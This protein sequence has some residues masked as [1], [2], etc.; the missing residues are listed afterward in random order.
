MNEA[1]LVSEF[2]ERYLI[3]I[4]GYVGY[5]LVGRAVNKVP[6]EYFPGKS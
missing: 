2:R 6:G 1:R 5:D 4:T 3:E